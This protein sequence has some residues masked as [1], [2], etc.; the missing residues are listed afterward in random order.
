[1]FSLEMPYFALRRDGRDR[2]R[3]T[4]RQTHTHT[5]TCKH[6]HTDENRSF[7]IGKRIF[8]EKQLYRP[9]GFK[10]IYIDLKVCSAHHYSSFKMLPK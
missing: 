2:D 3:Q 8:K 4:D 10:H 9:L 5:H 1:M 6:T 7:H